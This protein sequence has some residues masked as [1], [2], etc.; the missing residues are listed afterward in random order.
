[1]TTTTDAQARAS[2]A[3]STTADEGKHVGKVASE[4]A[5]NVAAEAADQA[6]NLADS[7]RSQIEEQGAAQRDRLAA[8]LSTLSDDLDAMA[9]GERPAPGMA[10]DAIQQVAQ[11][12]RELSGRLDGRDLNELLDDVRGFARRR[13][14]TF[15]LGSLAA[16]VVA[17]RL[18]RGAKNADSTPS[19]PKVDVPRQKAGTDAPPPPPAPVTGVAEPTLTGTGTGTGIGL[20]SGSDVDGPTPSGLGSGDGL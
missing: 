18:L 11:R 1:M 12:A 8:T 14:G 7:A 5:K 2:E 16:G 20:G 10:N 3:A 15:L 9:R 13:P 4:E 19:A 17:G 6:R